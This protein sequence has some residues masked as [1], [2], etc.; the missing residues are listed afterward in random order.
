MSRIL[1]EE[2]DEPRLSPE[3]VTPTEKDVNEKGVEVNPDSSEGEDLEQ[4][5]PDVALLPVNVRNTVSLTD[6]PT[7]PTITFRYFVLTVIFISPG[8]FLSQ[9]SYFRTTYAPYV[10]PAASHIFSS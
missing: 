10:Q 4:L 3:A 2:R 8:A 5:E 6:D 9:M 7:L 1:P